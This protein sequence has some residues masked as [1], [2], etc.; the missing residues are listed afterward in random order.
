M[1]MSLN[2]YALSV[3]VNNGDIYQPVP[4][5]GRFLTQLDNLTMYEGGTI[6]SYSNGTKP[7]FDFATINIYGGLVDTNV[8]FDRGPSAMIEGGVFNGITDIDRMNN[9]NISGGVFNGATGLDR[10]N[11][12]TISGGL[13]VSAK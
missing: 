10:T 1:G 4:N 5:V 6:I 12:I 7:W 11:D 13:F 2:T 8:L 9:I 3:T